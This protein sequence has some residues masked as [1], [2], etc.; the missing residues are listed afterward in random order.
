MWHFQH[1][2]QTISSVIEKDVSPGNVFGDAMRR[3]F[4]DMPRVAVQE[5]S[6]ESEIRKLIQNAAAQTIAFM[7]SGRFPLAHD[8]DTGV[9]Y[10]DLKV[11]QS[12]I[13]THQQQTSVDSLSKLNIVN[14]PDLIFS[15]EASI[16]GFIFSL[17]DSEPSEIAVI[18]L[19]SIEIF[20]KWNKL[21]TKD[22]V[23]G[24][25]VGWLQVDNHCPGAPYP[26]A[27][28]PEGKTKEKSDDVPNDNILDSPFLSIQ[29]AFA[30]K[31]SSGISVRLYSFCV[32]VLISFIHYLTSF[33]PSLPLW[34][35][36]NEVSSLSYRIS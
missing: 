13:N 12:D 32:T 30:P 7:V 22:A 23:I 18:L 6:E 2:F 8:V 1:S 3:Q 20:A 9:F 14:D 21:R 17:V 35:T 31:H 19:S 25:N 34:H 28:Y 24:I 27:V 10:K 29:M 15:F 16:N 33:L 5:R 26:V 4:F 36:C 11:E